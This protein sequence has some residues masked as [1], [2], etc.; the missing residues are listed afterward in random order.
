[1][2]KI[3]LGPYLMVH[4]ELVECEKRI[5]GC[6]KCDQELPYML[7]GITMHFCP[8]C[9]EKVSEVT[10]KHSIQHPFP[11]ITGSLFSICFDK[12][13]V[14]YL[15]NIETRTE[16]PG[17]ICFV[18]TETYAIHHI[19]DSQ[20]DAAIEIFKKH[21]ADAIDIITKKYKQEPEIKWGIISYDN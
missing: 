14:L 20:Q 10:R 21:F 8:K 2:S 3:Y 11:I 5:L 4:P 15:P 17:Y 9:G 19:T 13:T 12:Q 7:A 18:D 6:V 16:F 1:M